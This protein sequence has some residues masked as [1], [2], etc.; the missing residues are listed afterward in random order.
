MA[1]QAQPLS[2]SEKGRRSL[3]TTLRKGVHST[4]KLTRARILLNL[5]EGRGPSRIA[6]EVGVHPNTVY[7]VRKKASEIGWEEAIEDHPRGGRPPEISA[8]ARAR[9]TALAGSAPPRGRGRW[10]LRLLGDKAVE[11]GLVDEISYETVREILKKTS[12][13]RT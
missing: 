8:E 1:Q 4:R 3:T 6:R 12:S 5:D 10:S 9:I 7:N 13:S 11:L 2:L